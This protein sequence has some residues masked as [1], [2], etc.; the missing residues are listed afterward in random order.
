VLLGALAAKIEGSTLDLVDGINLPVMSVIT[1]TS[2]NVSKL[3]TSDI[4]K[5]DNGASQ[6]Y[7]NYEGRGKLRVQAPQMSIPYD[8]KDYDGNKKFKLTLSFR[9]ADK[10]P[11]M[12]KFH[13][14]LQAVDNYIIDVATA[15]AG[16]WFKM[17]GASRE[18]ISAFYT[19]T[20]KV[21]KDQN[22]NPKD[23]PPTIGIKLGQRNDVFDAELYDD[24]NQM[25]EGVTPLDVLRRGAEIIPI[26]DATGIWVADKKFGVTWKL[27]QARV[28]VP[29]EGSAS[30]G[31]LGVDEDMPAV[32]ASE[33]ADLMAAVL[34]TVS[35][36]APADEDDD[37]DEDDED[38]VVEAPPVPKKVAPAPVV[39]KK[40]VKKVVKA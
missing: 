5:L 15:N 21:S 31:F 20:I 27:H 17:P 16:K 2:F 24:T 36:P 7:L 34:P 9:G 3:S 25:M 39:A 12:A 37:D 11:K 22:G 1:P 30:R 33:E 4:K 32:S 14:M 10:N 40:V 13:E 8:A 26:L 38:N 6:V 28:V 19:S 23:Y 35:A 29:A 18:L